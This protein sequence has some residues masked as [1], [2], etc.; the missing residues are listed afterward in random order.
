MKL[1]QQLFGLS[2]F[3]KSRSKVIVADANSSS[4][5][6]GG[7]AADKTTDVANFACNSTLCR[8]LPVNGDIVD[9]DIVV[10]RVPDSDR[11]EITTP[12]SP[13]SP[14]RCWS[15]TANRICWGSPSARRSTTRRGVATSAE[16]ERDGLTEDSK[17]PRSRSLIRTNPWLP[18]SSPPTD[19]R[20]LGLRRSPSGSGS[21]SCPPTPA[22]SPAE[23]GRRWRLTETASGEETTAVASEGYCSVSSLCTMSDSAT[24]STTACSDDMQMSVDSLASLFPTLVCSSSTSFHDDKTSAS[25]T[26]CESVV[27]SGIVVSST[28]IVDADADSVSTVYDGEVQRRRDFDMVA[29]GSTKCVRSSDSETPTN[30]SKKT[31]SS[32]ATKLTQRLSALQAALDRGSADDYDFDADVFPFGSKVR[33]RPATT[34]VTQQQQNQRP[35]TPTQPVLSQSRDVEE[36]SSSLAASVERLRRGRV[37]VDGAF[38]RA[39]AED[40]R[41]QRERTRLRRRMVE[42]QR[43]VLLGTL[44]DLR[45]ELDGQCRRLQAAYDVVLTNRW[46]LLHADTAYATRTAANLQSS[47]CQ[48]AVWESTTSMRRCT[49]LLWNVIDFSR[50]L[51]SFVP[52]RS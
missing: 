20:H 30:Q 51:C 15:P 48:P 10:S 36:I 33:Q 44:R 32:S 37:A 4:S 21:A 18:A 25:G 19:R 22:D 28:S 31:S 35:D 9:N 23:S 40:G 46:P 41:R 16:L 17:L 39:L 38:G 43:D 8:Q 27:D 45:R 1:L 6:A 2:L 24:V 34:P 47:V 12:S 49:W 26:F 52:P 5:S 13:S 14:M 7:L 11:S 50:L 29:I 3:G 42:A